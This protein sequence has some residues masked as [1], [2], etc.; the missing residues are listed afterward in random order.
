MNLLIP[1]AKIF[2]RAKFMLVASLP[3]YQPQT[4]FPQLITF[5]EEN[6]TVDQQDQCSTLEWSDEL[7]Q[8]AKATARENEI[9]RPLPIIVLDYLFFIMKVQN[10]IDNPT[11]SIYYE[12]ISLP[13]ILLVLHVR[14]VRQSSTT[15]L[16]LDASS[17]F[18][19]FVS[20]FNLVADDGVKR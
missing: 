8:I 9:V 20:C 19:L 18:S 16:T 14:P 3:L 2:R 13:Y 12:K 7:M 11:S 6:K 1:S 17:S 10:V 15:T 5:S 4:D